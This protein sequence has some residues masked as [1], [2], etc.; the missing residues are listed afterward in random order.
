MN[1]P[2]KKKRRFEFINKIGGLGGYLLKLA[3]MR[4]F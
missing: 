2:R 3:Q 1:G 4:R